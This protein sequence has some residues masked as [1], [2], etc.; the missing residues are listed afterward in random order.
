MMFRTISTLSFSI[1]ILF[2]MAQGQFKHMQYNLTLY[3]NPFGCDETTNNSNE[4]DLALKEIIDYSQPDILCVNELRDQNVWADRIL[5]QVL[6]VDEDLW[7]RAALTA[8]VT[9]SSIINGFFYREDKFSLYSQEVVYQA[10]DGSSLLRPIDLYTLY[11]DN[12]ELATGDTTF[13]TCVVAHLAA[14]D[15]VERSDQTAALMSRIQLRGP[16]NYIFSG[17][18]NMDSANE[19]AFQNLISFPDV[20]LEFHDPITVSNTWNNNA[21]VSDYHTQSTRYSDTNLGCFSGG[22]LDD[23]FD[24]TLI[25]PS[26][27]AG[28]QG[29]HYINGSYTV[30][31]QSGNDY[32]QQLQII[33]NGVVPDAVALALYDMSDHLPVVTEFSTDMTISLMETMAT[34]FNVIQTSSNSIEIRIAKSG[35]FQVEIYDLSGRRVIDQ[36]GYGTDVQ[37]D[38]SHCTNGVYIVSVLGENSQSVK[39]IMLF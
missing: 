28:S 32:N 12:V 3:G 15:P 39:K 14:T 36:K 21:S 2:G 20:Q 13:F 9:S 34:E 30:L 31:G 7:S 27:L 8:N 35:R 1:L 19:E 29:V 18:L 5:N 23:R 17:D 10:L 22:G 38:I 24:I 11:I 6:N 4:K 26:I 16:G 25:S 37:L 33:N